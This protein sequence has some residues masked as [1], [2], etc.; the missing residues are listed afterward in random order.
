MH[1]TSSSMSMRCECVS[2]QWRKKEVMV[3]MAVPHTPQDTSA[4]CPGF[5][6]GAGVEWLETEN[7][8]RRVMIVVV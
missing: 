8:F 2:S 3:R 6:V 7:G 5:V 4:P 1:F